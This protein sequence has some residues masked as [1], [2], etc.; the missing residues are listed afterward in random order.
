MHL[1]SD[2]LELLTETEM[3]PPL[4]SLET[5]RLAQEALFPKDPC[6]QMV[7]TLAPEYL[8]RDYFKA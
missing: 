1:D 5:L 6:T 4:Q 7:Y 3:E 2:N 8:Y